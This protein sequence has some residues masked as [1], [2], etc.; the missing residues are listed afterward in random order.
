MAL[1]TA[2]AL[3]LLQYYVLLL[4]YNV[5]QNRASLLYCHTF[6][7]LLDA[8]HLARHK[9]MANVVLSTSLGTYAIAYLVHLGIPILLL[10]RTALQPLFI[11]SFISS[12]YIA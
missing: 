2:T 8:Q 11:H 3:Q 9:D 5:E 1:L 12:I 4:T 6:V 7:L 10:P